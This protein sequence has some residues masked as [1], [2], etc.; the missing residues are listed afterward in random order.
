MQRPLED[1]FYLTV[2]SMKK[3]FIG[4]NFFIEPSRT[5]SKT[6]V[7]QDTSLPGKKNFRSEFLTAGQ[8]GNLLT[9]YD[10]LCSCL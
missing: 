10:L 5:R 7:E 1:F 4:G 2:L 8:D 6:T 9:D 3:G